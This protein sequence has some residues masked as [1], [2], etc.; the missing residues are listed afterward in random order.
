MAPPIVNVII[1]EYI[2]WCVAVDWIYAGVSVLFSPRPSP[3]ASAVALPVGPVA[4]ESHGRSPH[5]AARWCPQREEPSEN[6]QW[7]DPWS[8]C[9]NYCSN[10]Y[11]WWRL[12]IILYTKCT[13]GFVFFFFVFTHLDKIKFSLSEIQV[14]LWLKSTLRLRAETVKEDKAGGATGPQHCRPTPS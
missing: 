5:P 1:D 3:P 7:P 13:R 6:S 9:G 11:A 10:Y 12:G 14:S 4:P 8:K 2:H